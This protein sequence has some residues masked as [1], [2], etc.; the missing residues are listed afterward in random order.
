MSVKDGAPERRGISAA[1]ALTVAGWVVALLVLV[2]N[3]AYYFPLSTDDDPYISYRYAWNLLNG[4]GLAWNPGERFQGYSN[5]LWVILNAAVSGLAGG[6]LNASRVISALSV[7][8]IAAT[9]WAALRDRPGDG[10][11]RRLYPVLFAMLLAACSPLVR[12]A[13]TGWEMMLF[14]ALLMGALYRY[15]LEVRGEVRSHTSLPLA[16][17]M[18]LTRSEGPAHLLTFAV[19]RALM[20]RRGERWRRAD[21][22][23]WAGAAGSLAIYLLWQFLYFGTLA[24]GPLYAKVAGQVEWSYGREYMMGVVVYSGIAALVFHLSGFAAAARLAPFA[25]VQW[26]LPAFIQTAIILRANG[27]MWPSFRV[28]AGFLP[29]VYLGCLS[30]WAAWDARLAGRSRMRLALRS[31]LCVIVAA[32]AWQNLSVDRV[33][34][35]R[36]LRSGSLREKWR[37]AQD[38]TVRKEGILAGLGS[39]LAAPKAGPFAGALTLI[40][41]S[42][43]PGEAIVFPDIG[44]VGLASGRTLYDQRGLVDRDAALSIYHERRLERD[45]AREYADR[46]LEKV[47]AGNAVFVGVATSATLVND[48]LRDSRW[49]RD[50]FTWVGAT[51]EHTFYLRNDR[52]A[53]PLTAAEREINWAR[54]AAVLPDYPVFRRSARPVP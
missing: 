19:L 54:A 33:S 12:Y 10:S 26:F 8:A 41:D 51:P 40:L 44:F 22:L 4:D 18:L 3:S 45:T 11:V 34:V 17:C 49:L 21:T 13:V 48:V 15:P 50:G 52:V 31:M 16:V 9:A 36:F 37:V 39:R 29:L 43:R 42:T 14:P 6:F 47:E 20:W 46:F 27:D 28:F 30:G 2:V 38:N 23:W 7:S 35:A 24:T 5:F 53:K 25:A 1:C 32:M